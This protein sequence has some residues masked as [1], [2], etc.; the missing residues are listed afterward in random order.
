MEICMQNNSS[1]IC[2]AFRKTVE[3]ADVC[4]GSLLVHLTESKCFTTYELTK[5]SKISMYA[6][7]NKREGQRKWVH[8]FLQRL[9]PHPH[10]V[11]REASF[12]QV[13]GF[14]FVCFSCPLKTLL[15]LQSAQP[16]HGLHAQRMLKVLQLAFIYM[17]PQLDDGMMFSILPAAFCATFLHFPKSLCCM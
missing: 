10:A 5:F 12:G 3:D 9:F 1:C 13:S 8:T 16:L 6:Y 4:E 11:C 17:E 15:K 2:L 7:K 14:V